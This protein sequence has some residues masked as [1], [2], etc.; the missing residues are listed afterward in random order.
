MTLHYVLN[1]SVRAYTARD[2]W[3]IGGGM[4]TI[5]KPKPMLLLLQRGGESAEIELAG[6]SP[7]LFQP[8]RIE[9]L[10]RSLLVLPSTHRK[11][12]Y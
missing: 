10:R 4:K 1:I 5:P 2:R 6:A 7:T 12:D 11:R 9:V 8:R 3:A